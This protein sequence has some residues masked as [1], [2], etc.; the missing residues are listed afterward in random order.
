[1]GVPPW[2]R[3]TD[4]RRHG[5]RRRVSQIYLVMDAG[6][7]VRTRSILMLTSFDL[8]IER[9]RF[10]RYVEASICALF[11]GICSARCSSA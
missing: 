7:A 3:S 2:C 6:E 1:M 4:A 5:D 11:A 8:L 9:Q 10:S